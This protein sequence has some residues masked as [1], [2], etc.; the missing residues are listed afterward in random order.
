M[1]EDEYQAAKEQAIKSDLASI[2]NRIRHTFNQG[3]ELGRESAQRTNRQAER[4]ASGIY[5]KDIDTGEVRKYGTNHHDALRISGDGRHLEY[6]N[7]QNGC[8]SLGGY[9]FVV[10]ENGLVPDEDEVLVRHGADAYFNIGGF[11]E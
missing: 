1:T 8:G 6:V 3:F 4:R 11:E 10:D 9:R 2:E 7:L 5:I